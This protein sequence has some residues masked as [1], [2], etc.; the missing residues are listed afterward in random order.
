[1][2][3]MK[4][5]G[6]GALLE[7]AVTQ[8]PLHERTCEKRSVGSEGVSRTAPPQPHGPHTCAVAASAVQLVAL[9]AD[10][11]EHA[12]QVLTAPEHTEVPENTLVHIWGGRTPAQRS[13]A[14]LASCSCHPQCQRLQGPAHIPAAPDLTLAGV[15]VLCGVEAHLAFTAVPPGG[16]ET[17]PVLAKVHVLRTLVPV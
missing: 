16:I 6:A 7:T 10:A 4:V 17:L 8:G 13:P 5:N 11:A 9:I 12:W 14:H 2:R 3:M 15:L 1:M